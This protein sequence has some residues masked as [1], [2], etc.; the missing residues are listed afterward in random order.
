MRVI[1]ETGPD[2]AEALH[3]R[4]IASFF[5]LAFPNHAAGPSSGHLWNKPNAFLRRL[6]FVDTSVPAYTAIIIGTTD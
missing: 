2:R 3:P 1:L 6:G 5:T 4:A